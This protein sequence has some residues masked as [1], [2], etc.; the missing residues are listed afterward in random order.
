MDYLVLVSL[1]LLSAVISAAEIGFF[2]VSETRL[3]ALTEGHGKRAALVLH[4]RANPQRLL[5]TIMIG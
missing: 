2:S 5:S 4:L 3:R 1:I